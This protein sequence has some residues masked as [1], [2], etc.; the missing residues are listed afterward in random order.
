MTLPWQG[1][2]QKKLTDY[3]IPRIGHSIGVGEDEI[4]AVLDVESRGVGFDKHGVIRLFEEHVFYRQLPK[5]LRQDA[6]K[7]GLAYP[8][9]RRN[10]KDN[11][12]RLLKAYAYNPEAALMACSWG[13]AQIMGFNFR[14]VGFDTVEDIVKT[15][16]KSD[17]YQLE[18]MVEFIKTAGLDDEL[19]NHDWAGF[20]RGYNGKGYKRNRYDEKLKKR[21]DWWK[22]KPDTN[23]SPE[24]AKKVQQSGVVYEC[25]YK[26]AGQVY[27][28]DAEDY[29]TFFPFFG[30]DAN[31]NLHTEGK[32][33]YL[34]LPHMITK[35]ERLDNSHLEDE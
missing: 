24:S 12:N 1:G 10:Y 30:V 25:A 15:F 32:P 35:I 28:A 14:T 29:S 33:V 19:R 8:K 16:A 6:V 9:W 4:H 21:Y 5:H 2:A 20:A 27:T 11:Y 31:F 22:S 7:K 23:W 18:A 26:Y 34:I 3:D 13:L 17:A